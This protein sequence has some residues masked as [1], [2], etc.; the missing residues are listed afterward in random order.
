MEMFHML[1]GQFCAVK[2]ICECLNKDL[3]YT[4]GG[5]GPPTEGLG[6]SGALLKIYAA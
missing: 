1:Q 6:I 4:A 5:L 3:D 2:K